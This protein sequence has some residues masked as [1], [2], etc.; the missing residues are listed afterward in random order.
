MCWDEA[1]P[2]DEWELPE[3]GAAGWGAM[4]GRKAAAGCGNGK[5]NWNS[6]TATF[7]LFSWGMCRE[8]SYSS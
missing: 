3:E 4:G 2:S 5:G 6:G 8:L 7:L 1:L